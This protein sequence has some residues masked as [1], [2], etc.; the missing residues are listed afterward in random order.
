M[1]TDTTIICKNCNTPF[2]KDGH[3]RHQLYCGKCHLNR[4]V[5]T[6]TGKVV[7]DNGRKIPE[8]RLVYER[9][10]GE[11][12]SGLD[13]HHI[14]GNVRNNDISNLMALSRGDHTRLH[15]ATNIKRTGLLRPIKGEGRKEVRVM[16]QELLSISEAAKILKIGQQTIRK[17][18]REGHINAFKF[19]RQ[20]RIINSDNWWLDLNNGHKKGE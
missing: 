19:G 18:C 1:N 7:Y 17:H 10:Y 13:I 3:I 15:K 14:D 11:I 16:R 8:S 4:T 6:N 20:W 5:E 2:T 9:A 12:P